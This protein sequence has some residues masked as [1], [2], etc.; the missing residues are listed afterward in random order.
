MVTGTIDVRI[1]A[2]FSHDINTGTIGEQ[3]STYLVTPNTYW[4]SRRTNA[5][6]ATRFLNNEKIKGTY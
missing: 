1:E 6:I 2:L 3:L 4:Y 5:A